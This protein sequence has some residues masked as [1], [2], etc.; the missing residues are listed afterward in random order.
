MLLTFQEPVISVDD[1]IKYCENSGLPVALDESID[2][3]KGD[4][5]DK[6]QQ[7]VHPGI[8]AVVSTKFMSYFPSFCFH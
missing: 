1:L 4:P 6:L 3:L 2:N 8:V 7:F 5:I